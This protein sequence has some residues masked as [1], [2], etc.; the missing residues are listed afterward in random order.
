MWANFFKYTKELHTVPT[1]HGI[2]GA[3]DVVSV[4]IVP[5]T[6]VRDA[7]QSVKDINFSNIC[8]IKMSPVQ[9]LNVAM[10]MNRGVEMQ[11]VHLQEW[12]RRAMQAGMSKDVSHL[13][14]VFDELAKGFVHPEIKRRRD[15]G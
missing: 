4:E 12:V 7:L 13:F 3:F 5:C 14:E 2:K 1:L 6:I 9:D 10:A 11:R 15:P 8:D